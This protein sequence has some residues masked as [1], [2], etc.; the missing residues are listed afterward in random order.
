MRL[1]SIVV[2]GDVLERRQRDVVRARTKLA[3][4]AGGAWTLN[5]A[6]GDQRTMTSD[7]VVSAYRSGVVTDETFCWKDGMGDWLPLREVQELYEVCAANS[8]AAPPPP[9]PASWARTEE[10]PRPPQ[11]GRVAGR[12]GADL[13]SSAAQAGGE[14]EVMTSAPVGTPHARPAPSPGPVDDKMTGERNENSVLFS[15]SALTAKGP[16]GGPAKPPAP[17]AEASGL[18]DIRQLSAQLHSTDD[19]KKNRIDDIMNLAGGGAFSPSLG[20]PILAAPAV[21]EY[22]APDEAGAPA[23]AAAEKK[24]RGVVIAAALGGVLRDRSAPSEPPSR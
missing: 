8:A 22:T 2:N 20:G 7:E 21:A 9:D 12:G 14:D 16:G 4:D 11:P 13:F 23:A 19:K 6:E 10:P 1:R 15:L 24:G 5:V 18:I 3:P 17:G